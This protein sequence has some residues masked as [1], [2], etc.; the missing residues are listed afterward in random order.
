[1]FKN[2]KFD[3]KKIKAVLFTK[4]TAIIMILIGVS[5]SLAISFLPEKKEN[6]VT[7]KI[8]VEE[9]REGLENR[10]KKLIKSISGAGN[11][12]VMITLKNST[13]YIY[14]TEK[15]SSES[16]FEESGKSESK[17][18]DEYKY[19]IVEDGNGGEKALIVTEKL[20]EVLGAV[21][22]CD[23]ADIPSV[24]SSLISA[25]GALLGISSNNI[26]VIKKS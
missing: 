12:E 8:T 15:K 20:P 19:I 7:E 17:L 16:V 23:G 5:V 11:C 6:A 13:E 18:G 9:Y 24:K 14:A 3:Y 25:V 26:C 1:M 10:L 2:F 21:I 4:K 22:V